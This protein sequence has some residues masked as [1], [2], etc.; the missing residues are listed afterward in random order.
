MIQAGHFRSLPRGADRMGGDV[1]QQIRAGGRADL[2]VD[3]AETVALAGQPQHRLG[4][5]AA[6][7]AI[8]PTGAEDQVIATG[9]PDQLFA[10]QLGR[11][12][13][14][15]RRGGIGFQP[16]LVAAAV[17][18]IVGGVMDQPGLACSV[19]CASTPGASALMVRTSS[20]SLSALS[21]AVCAA[22]L[23]ITSGLTTAHRVSQAF[24]IGEVAAQFFAV[25]IQRDQLAQRRKAALQFP[26][27]LAVLAEQQYFHQARPA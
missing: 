9:S 23:T 17:E 8:H 14:T 13:H 2:V 24:Q 15:Q 19:S 25:V 7:R 27:D 16:R 21:T 5:V 18:H 4:E 1:G 11:A 22:A 6:A 12:I 10:F 3:H 20:G 26:A